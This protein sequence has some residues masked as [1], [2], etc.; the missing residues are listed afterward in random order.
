MDVPG[1]SLLPSHLYGHEID[2]AVVEVVGQA[3]KLQSGL[4]LAVL[5]LDVPG[6]KPRLLGPRVHLRHR[7]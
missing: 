5:P 3:G 2:P 4:A 7:K 6:V 1:V